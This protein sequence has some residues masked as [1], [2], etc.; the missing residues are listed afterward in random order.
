MTFLGLDLGTSEVKAM[1]VDD[2][3]RL[4][5][6]DAV[7]LAIASPQPLWSEQSPDE[8]WHATLKAIDRVRSAAPEAFAALRGIGL[9]GQMHGA[10]LL[11][12]HQRVLRPAILW[13]DTRAHAECIEL[14]ALVPQSRQITG[15]LAMPGFTAPK[16]LW[17]Q[18]YEP[19]IRARVDKVL[20]P[21]DYI[22]FRLTGE[23]VS[24][25]SDAAG[26]LWLDV[27]GRDW[28]DRMLAATGLDRASMP[29]L[30][31]GSQAGAALR[32]A[33]AAEWGIA[34]EVVVAGGAG[35]NAAAAV[36]IGAVSPGDAFISLG[37][38]GVMFVANERFLPN[39]AQAVHA[40]CH[41]LPQRW[42]QMSVM[43]SAAASLTWASQLTQT[44]VGDLAGLAQR[45]D[46]GRAPLF[47]PYLNGERTPHNNARASGTLLGLNGTSDRAAIG[48]AVMEG[49]AFGLA[50]GYAALAATGSRV[51]TASFVGGG[52]RSRFWGELIASATGITLLRHANGDF[53][54]A[55]GAARL[56]RLAV[57]GEAVEAVC[58]VPPVAETICPNPEM[59]A[60]LHARH[61][62]FRRAY[63]ALEPE[64]ARA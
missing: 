58:T 63:A 42:H 62:R 36:G 55:F 4:L 9:S 19:A 44:P 3:Q 18:K 61:D 47:L 6:S 51:G 17:L 13:N 15:N 59:A 53:G 45:A 23:F 29:R 8:W 54:G 33:L 43:L 46:A 22:A 12:K 57:G 14:E 27:A 2:E 1:L 41:A 5:A 35:D 25:M 7:R 56:A 21:K 30:V 60:L 16:L 28:S 24:E 50:D 38:S 31:E 26:T 64:F 11:D 48:Y 32:P 52:S 10:V 20:L 37:T 40:F 49:V 34:H 39:P